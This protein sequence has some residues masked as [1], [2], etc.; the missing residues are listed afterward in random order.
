MPATPVP[1]VTTLLLDKD[2]NPS[3]RGRRPIAYQIT[4]TNTGTGKATGV[5]VRD[6][7]PE[8]LA[9]V[10]VPRG[11]VLKGG[12]IRWAVGD[13]AP[14]ATKT[15]GVWM[16]PVRNQ[17]RRICNTAEAGGSNTPVTQDTRCLRVIRVAGVTR[18]PVTG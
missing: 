1:P 6:R 18:T 5:V 9:V 11:A 4:V 2:S 8:G 3:S 17:A 12:V 16:R 7:I 13:I 10:R 15:V 14:G